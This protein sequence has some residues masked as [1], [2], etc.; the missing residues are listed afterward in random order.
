MARG[1]SLRM[2]RAKGLC[3]LPGDKLSFLARVVA[4][5][6]KLKFAVAVVTTT[7]LSEDYRQE[8]APATC[9]LWILRPRGGGTATTVLAAL[10]MLT[11][12][13]THLWLHPVDLPQVTV[14]SVSLLKRQ[15]LAHPRAVLVP[16][17]AG[18]PGHP[19]VLPVAPFADLIERPAPT[20]MRPW[21][22]ELTREGPN[23]MAPLISV[24]LTDEGVVTDYDDASRLT[25]GAGGKE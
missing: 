12:R 5:Y 16:E 22:L 8:L 20:A 1:A 10:S 18:R 9:D 25:K 17:H 23:Q 7:Q 13:A 3:R 2:G 21:L 15:S 19:V 6:R 24:P 14:H 4:L 11:D